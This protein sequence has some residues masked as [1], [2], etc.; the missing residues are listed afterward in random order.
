M[1]R[2][3]NSRR[4]VAALVLIISGIASALAGSAGTGSAA[5]GITFTFEPL[6]GTSNNEIPTVSYGKGI[7][8][9]LLMQNGTNSAPHST[10][11]VITNNDAFYDSSTATFNGGSASCTGSSDGHVLECPLPETLVQGD[12]FEAFIRFIAPPAST[13]ITKVSTKATL[14]VTAQTV[15]GNKNKGTTLA[16]STLET[17]LTSQV[18]TDN[19]YL[20]NHEE[21]ST[22]EESF[23]T[24]HPQNF[25]LTTPT[26]LLNAFGVAVGIQD[27]VEKPNDPCVGDLNAC[28]ILTIPAA[29][30]AETQSPPVIPFPGNPF[31]TGTETHPYTWEMNAHYTGGFNL[32]GVLHAEDNQVV[33]DQVPSC[34]SLIVPVTNPT[35]NP[36]AAD[37]LCYDTLT[38][39]N[40]N[41]LLHATGRG[42]ENGGLGWN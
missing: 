2:L 41:K 34:A 18:T 3:K 37:P 38:Q 30:F 36:T 33:P 13:A 40:P 5:P 12:T 35:G 27:K 28:T 11:I 15:G 23:T 14:S 32:T 1:Q 29:K 42:L 9:H 25:T 7:G 4:F 8:F 19:A 10:K 21:A 39:D 22:E 17:A 31:Y 20:K 16:S 26:G 6:I 24:S